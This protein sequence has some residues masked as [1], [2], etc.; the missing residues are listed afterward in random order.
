[1]SDRRRKDED[2]CYYNC[3]ECRHYARD[4]L[5]SKRTRKEQRSQRV[6]CEFKRIFWKVMQE[7]NV[8][9]REDPLLSNVNNL[10]VNQKKALI[11]IL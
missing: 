1:M 9:P 6:E 8:K 11:F 5:L 7:W 10:N 2:I 4:C 3:K